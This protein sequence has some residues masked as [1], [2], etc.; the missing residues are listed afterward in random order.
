MRNLYHYI[1]TLYGVL[2]YIIYRESSKKIYLSM[3]YIH[4]ASNGKSTLILNKIIN[5]IDKLYNK[6]EK[7]LKEEILKENKREMIF[8]EEFKFNY[9]LVK[10]ILL[11]GYASDQNK[12]HS[13]V[14]S[15]IIEAEKLFT[16]RLLLSNNSYVE[17]QSLTKSRKEN[18][19]VRLD[20][21]SESILEH[22]PEIQSIAKSSYFLKIAESFL[23]VPPSLDSVAAWRTFP[24]GSDSSPSSKG[25]Q[26]F[27]YDLD[28]LSWLKIFIYLTNV[29]ENSGPH[30]YV[31]GSH[32]PEN[33]RKNILKRGYV[34]L[35]DEELEFV[36]GK[37]KLK[38]VMG[39]AG[40][41]LYGNTLAFHKGE[42]PRSSE[43]LILELQYTANNYGAQP[44]KVKNRAL[45]NKIFKTNSD[46][47]NS[48]AFELI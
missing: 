43:R 36:Y 38:K 9:S 27:H 39:S 14:I 47:I 13:S 20:Y 23:G 16:G 17:N 5:F 15:K 26:L 28:R 48:H 7:K 37:N 34:R 41:I 8:E 40:T 19:P 46:G 18:K 35:E 45:V 29:D 24:L 11:S 1:L 10:E 6:K 12:L 44:I 30:W 33:K 2:H 22:S 31:E 4:A 42:S 3:T 21:Y 32:I 25:A